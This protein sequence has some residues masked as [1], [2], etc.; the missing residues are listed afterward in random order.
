MSPPTLQARDVHV[1]Y[2]Q[3]HALR[4]VDLDLAAGECVA[5]VGESGSGKTT[6]LKLFNR[7]VDADSGTVTVR[8]TPVSTSAPESLRR[9]I[10]YVQQEGGLLPH[11]SVARNVGLVP[12]LLGWDADRIRAR[13]ADLLGVVGLPAETFAE[14][15]PRELSGGQ[16]QRVAF[17]R[18]L[19]ADPDILLLDEPFGA[20]DPLI[21]RQMQDEFPGWCRDKSVLLVT[22]DLPEALRLGDR[23]AVLR[24]GR[25]EQVGSP[26]DLR[27]TPATG[28]VRA[29]LAAQA[30][31]A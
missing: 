18:A 19:A 5:L 28:Y 14:R 23:V 16:R 31:G 6:L 2:A 21:R 3:T 25:L 7:L 20:L 26:A 10:G 13:T 17:A 4:G 29:L 9:G 12:D 15:R 24:D 30:V 22:H 1:H 11:W 27:D 8:G